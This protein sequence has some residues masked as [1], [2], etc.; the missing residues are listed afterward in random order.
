MVILKGNVKMEP[1][2]EKVWGV[3]PSNSLRLKCYFQ[4]P[5]VEIEAQRGLVTCS[6]SPKYYLLELELNAYLDVIKNLH[7]IMG[8][9]IG[10]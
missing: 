3:R 10:I 1:L 5:D 8:L 9:C 7:N 6:G 4:F 2:E